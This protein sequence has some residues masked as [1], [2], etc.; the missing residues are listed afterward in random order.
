[1]RSGRVSVA[2]AA[3]EGRT[4]L[5]SRKVAVC[6]ATYRRPVGLARLL[7]GLRMLDLG[8]DEPLSL[9]VIVVDNDV[10]ASARTVCTQLSQDS[11]WP[12]TYLREER[13]RH[14]IRA[15]HGGAL[16]A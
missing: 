11:P 15:E 10:Q 7:R 6:I 12:I 9:E 2:R 16:R 3:A 1:M 13:E 8:C 5:G 4:Q 14:P